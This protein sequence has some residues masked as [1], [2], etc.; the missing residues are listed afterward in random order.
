MKW[1]LSPCPLRK[2]ERRQYIE[3]SQEGFIGQERVVGR[4]LHRHA[5]EG[6]AFLS[7]DVLLSNVEHVLG[8]AWDVKAGNV[9]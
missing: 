3:A 9:F 5:D 4:R 8:H 2:H 7:A 1:R 6:L